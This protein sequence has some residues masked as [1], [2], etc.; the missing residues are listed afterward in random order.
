[1]LVQTRINVSLTVAT[2]PAALK[3]RETMMY[4]N[5]IILG[6]VG[7]QRIESTQM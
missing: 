4:L 5:Q 1:M 2:K 7:S 6:T 3:S